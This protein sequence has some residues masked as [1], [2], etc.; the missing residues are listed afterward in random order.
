MQTNYDEFERTLRAD[1]GSFALCI[2][3]HTR[4]ERLPLHARLFMVQCIID[5]RNVGTKLSAREERSKEET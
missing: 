2:L 1:Y 4:H 3:P 5:K